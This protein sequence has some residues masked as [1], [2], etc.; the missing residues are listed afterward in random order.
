MLARL[1]KQSASKGVSHDHGSSSDIDP[2]LLLAEF[3]LP[4]SLEQADVPAKLDGLTTSM[5][6]DLDEEVSNAYGTTLRGDID[7]GPSQML[8]ELRGRSDVRNKKTADEGSDND[9]RSM[10]AEIEGNTRPLACEPLH[11]DSDDEDSYEA[12]R[13]RLAHLTSD[14]RPVKATASLVSHDQDQ[15]LD[16][17][18][19][20][21]VAALQLEASGHKWEEVQEWA[22]YLFSTGLDGHEAQQE[23]RQ[24]VQRATEDL[25]RIIKEAMAEERQYHAVE[26]NTRMPRRLTVANLAADAAEEDV[27]R[28]FYQWRLEVYDGSS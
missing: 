18:L 16:S 7:H 15:P 6:I 12:L 14:A 19:L 26:H 2:R 13:L 9:P 22:T 10:L 25:D 24:V 27:M 4:S 1:E 17:N 23:K 21:Y 28:F 8:A 3:G 20:P 11:D 5:L